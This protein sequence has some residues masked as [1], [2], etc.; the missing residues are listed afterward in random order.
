VQV[1][2]LVKGSTLHA[3]RSMPPQGTLSASVPGGNRMLLTTKAPAVWSGAEP[4]G[5]AQGKVDA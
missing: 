1:P 3:P 2:K 5:Q 4:A